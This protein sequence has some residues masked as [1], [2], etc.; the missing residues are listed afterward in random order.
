MK[1]PG[2]PRKNKYASAR[3][4]NWFNPVYWDTITEVAALPHIKI[5]MS[6]TEIVKEL[7]RRSSRFTLLSTQWFT[8][9]ITTQNDGT[10]R[11]NPLA[12]SKAADAKR[13][14]P[15]KSTRYGVLV[16]LQ[17]S[18]CSFDDLTMPPS[19]PRPL[20]PSY[21]PT[22]FL[23]S[24]I[25]APLKSLSHFLSFV[26]SLSLSSTPSNPSSSLRKQR[27]EAD[28]DVAKPLFAIS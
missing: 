16:S 24:Q 19:S 12:L 14:S 1:I 28:S 2:R 21:L 13:Y 18:D 4:I 11:W 5:K 15:A 6:A 20:T 17:L 23:P 27:M 22:S 3:R 10:R 26:Q 25:C 7:R 9:Y 8:P